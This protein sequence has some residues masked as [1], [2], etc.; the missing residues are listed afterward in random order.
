MKYLLTIF[1]ILVAAWGIMTSSSVMA[2]EI[3]PGPE[4]FQVHCAGCHPNGGNIIR[5][6]KTL[7]QKALK[8]YGVDSL[9]AI[10]ALVT[11]GKNNMPAFQTRLSEQ[12]IQAVSTYVLEAAA[13]DWR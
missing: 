2:A 6:G 3:N 9:E 7:K 8:K 1:L 5:R 4:I 11:N 12:Q 13:K 10:A